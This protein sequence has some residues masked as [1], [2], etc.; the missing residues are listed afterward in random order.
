M[1]GLQKMFAEGLKN[2]AND[3]NVD[4]KVADIKGKYLQDN[5]HDTFYDNARNLVWKPRRQMDEALSQVAVLIMPA[6]PKKD[7]ALPSVNMSLKGNVL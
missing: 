5:Y 6:S 2:R 1:T 7:R 4:W 3:L